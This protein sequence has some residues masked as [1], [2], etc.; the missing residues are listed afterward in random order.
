MKSLALIV[1]GVAVVAIPIFSQ[2]PTGV[3]RQFEVASIKPTGPVVTQI[4]I[5]R[6][7]GGRFIAQGFSVR[8]LMARAYSVT[9]SRIFGG[10]AWLQSDRFNIE[11]K[12]AARD[13]SPDGNIAADQ[14][15][16]M[17]QGLLED[18]FKLKVHRETREVPVYELV[19]AKGGSKLKLS[20][21]Q[22]PPAPL[23]PPVLGLPVQRG[24]VP[25]PVGRIR[26]SQGRGN[27]TAYGSAA[28]LTVLTNT[29]SQFLGRTVNDKT[30]LTGLFDFDLKWTPGA[31]QV[32]GAFGP[33]DLPPPPP[34]DASSPSIFTALQ[35]QLGLRLESAKGS[36][37]A[38][39]VDSAE[40]PSEN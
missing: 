13:L 32:P 6:Q 17:L 7:P 21:D 37:D 24:A 3:R 5:A 8:M 16:L 38:I 4:T 26:G 18:R 1:L 12:A 28:P 25:G 36:V 10:P 34:A 14:L 15:P 11:A 39:V 40:K 22:T 33:N 23:P 31:E 35:E 20:D 29:L 2:A 19:V 27:G 9:D 30:G